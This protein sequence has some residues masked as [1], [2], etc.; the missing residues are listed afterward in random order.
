M[1]YLDVD[2]QESVLAAFQNGFVSPMPGIGVGAK[3]K[4]QNI[5]QLALEALDYEDEDIYELRLEK[6]RFRLLEKETTR[7]REMYERWRQYFYP[8]STC[9]EHDRGRC[10]QCS[11]YAQGRGH[12]DEHL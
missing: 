2:S 10:A 11:R 12:P 4:T 5:V 9:K 6:E 7:A 1:R 8:D 3:M